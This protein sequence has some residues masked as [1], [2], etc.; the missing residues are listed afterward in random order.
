MASSSGGGLSGLGELSPSMEFSCFPALLPLYVSAYQYVAA[1]GRSR[2]ARAAFRG[3][4][5]HVD[6]SQRA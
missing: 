1:F 5:K 2:T 4:E 6:G 3:K